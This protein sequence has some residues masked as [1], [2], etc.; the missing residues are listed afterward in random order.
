M[1]G[2]EGNGVPPLP[3]C[4]ASKAMD[5]EEVGSVMVLSFGNPA[6]YDGAVFK[7]CGAG[8]KPMFHEL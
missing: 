6:V 8:F 3:Q 7:V 4:I 1:R 5:E 2:E